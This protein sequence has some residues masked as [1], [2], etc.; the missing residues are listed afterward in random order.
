MFGVIPI[1]RA[2]VPRLIGRVSNL[3]HWDMPAVS[4]FNAILVSP[5]QTSLD[6]GHDHA[7]A[8]ASPHASDWLRSSPPRLMCPSAIR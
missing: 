6:M 8:V 2:T 7:L 1:Y 5:V 3:K 4:E